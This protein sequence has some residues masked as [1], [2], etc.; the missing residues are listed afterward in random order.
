MAFSNPLTGGQ[1]A[2]VRP[3]IKSPNFVSGST[4]WTIKRDGSV[5]FNNGVFRGTVTAS[6]FL[7]TDFIINSSGFFVYNGTPAAGNMICSIAAAAGTDSFGNAYGQ[8]FNIGNFAG[9]HFGIDDAGKVYVT[10]SSSVLV[11]FIDSSTGAM[12]FGATTTPHFIIDPSTETMTTY[13]GSG[14][15]TGQWDPGNDRLI[16]LDNVALRF[17]MIQGGKFALGLI[18]AAGSLPTAAQIT[19]AS[20]LSGT[21]NLLTLS[22][23]QTTSTNSADAVFFNQAAGKSGVNTGNANVP[24]ALVGDGLGTSDADLLISGSLVKT[25]KVSNIFTWITPTIT[26]TNWALSGFAGDQL[27]QYRLDAMDNLILDGEIHVTAIV[28]ANTTTLIYTIPFTNYRPKAGRRFLI[29]QQT[30]GG[31]TFATGVLQSN[32]NLSIINPTATVNPTIFSFNHTIP[33]GNIA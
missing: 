5:E 2:L 11:D 33:L 21:P 24:F 14:N 1:G 22:S 29:W 7:G 32:G 9:A 16:Q 31:G 8:G 15:I 20:T 4:G 28:P 18:T 12:T 25:D 6:T 17:T 23:G 13:D 30:A 3:A 10:N 26:A 19:N 27:L